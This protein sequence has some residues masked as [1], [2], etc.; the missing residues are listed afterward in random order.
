MATAVAIGVSAAPAN[1]NTSRRN[2]AVEAA[3]IMATEG[4]RNYMT[5]KRKAAERLASTPA[6][7]CPATAKST[8]NCAPTRGFTAARSTPT[9]AN[10]APDRHHSHAIA[11]SRLYATPGRAGARWHRRQPLADFAAPVQRPAGRNPLH[12]QGLGVAYHQEQRRIRW[13]DGSHRTVQLLVTEV[14]GAAVEL[15]LFGSSGPA[16][17]AALPD[18]RAPA[19]AGDRCLEVESLLEPAESRSRMRLKQPL[20]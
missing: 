13:H 4:Q 12:L 2:V 11:S 6:Q 17:G 8:K 5:A 10:T 20:R 1:P 15:A 19:K 9:P 3:R 14:N 18:R 7:P 16:P